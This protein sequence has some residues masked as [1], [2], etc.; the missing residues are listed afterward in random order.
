MHE[1]VT[2]TLRAFS[3]RNQHSLWSS[4]LEDLPVALGSTANLTEW[5]ARVL[6]MWKAR[7]FTVKGG[8]VEEEGGAVSEAFDVPMFLC[9]VN[10][11]S[12][13]GKGPMHKSSGRLVLACQL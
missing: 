12:P 11:K 7:I 2:N 9:A 8:G 6:E 13:V 3:L 5:Q 10:L 1:S 4:F